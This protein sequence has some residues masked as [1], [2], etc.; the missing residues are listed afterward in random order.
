MK[1]ESGQG[2]VEYALILI[3]AAIILCAGIALINSLD[4]NGNGILDDKERITQPVFSQEC[5]N[6]KE[7]PRGEC[8]IAPIFSEDCINGDCTI[9]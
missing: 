9:R 1:K 3:L 5:C 7:C 8:S 2:L 6:G 4:Q